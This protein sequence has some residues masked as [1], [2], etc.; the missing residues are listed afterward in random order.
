MMLTVAPADKKRAQ[1]VIGHWE[2][3]AR[4]RTVRCVGMVGTPRTMI[5]HPGC[6][7]IRSAIVPCLD[8]RI[9]IRILDKGPPAFGAVATPVC[10]T[11]QI[12]RAKAT[13]DMSSAPSRLP[14]FSEIR[15]E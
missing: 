2:R 14:V 8:I 9:V 11:R 7:W 13:D 12:R 5:G 1:V 15:E 6:S 4:V 3:A 10:R